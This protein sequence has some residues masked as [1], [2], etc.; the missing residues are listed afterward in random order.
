MQVSA[1]NPYRDIFQLPD[2]VKVVFK[3]TGN[4]HIVPRGSI[5]ISR[6]STIISKGIIN[7][8]SLPALPNKSISITTLLKHQTRAWLPARYTLVTEFHYDGL[9]RTGQIKQSFWYIPPVWVLVAI[10]LIVFSPQI[11][12]KGYPKC[13]KLYQQLYQ[14]LKKRTKKAVKI[15]VKTIE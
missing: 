5:T 3:N 11:Y 6:G 4:V 10:V 7:Q 13:L 15:T 9:E 8:N 1:I 12:K 2:A 14:G